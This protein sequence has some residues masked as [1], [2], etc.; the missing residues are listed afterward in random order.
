MQR[1]RLAL[2]SF[3]IFSV[4]GTSARADGPVSIGP[5]HL[6]MT[7]AEAQ[8]VGTNWAPRANDA[9][10]VQVDVAGVRV[11]DSAFTMHLQFEKG[12]LLIMHG[13][14]SAVAGD[15]AACRRKFDGLLAGMESQ[16]GALD[17]GATDPRAETQ[18]SP[19]GSVIA[20]TPLSGELNSIDAFRHVPHVSVDALIGTPDAATGFLCDLYVSATGDDAL[21]EQLAPA[22]PLPLEIA[23]AHPIDARA[24]LTD[25][26]QYGASRFYPPRAV[27]QRIEGYV[28]L[29]C[30]VLDTLAL[31]CAVSHEAPTGLHFGDAALR[32]AT[33]LNVP[34]TYEGQP[35]AGRRL[36]VSLPFSIP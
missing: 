4:S 30:L 2:I 5:L 19:G 25:P 29:E 20:T 18:Q 1:F 33:T 3:A 13:K 11:G 32:V 7:V 16:V 9:G 24:R 17:G 14:A 35:T 6:G 12:R 31:R 27:M 22:Q 26:S 23:S 34:E 10:A 21:W 28:D 8:A 15:S 36:H